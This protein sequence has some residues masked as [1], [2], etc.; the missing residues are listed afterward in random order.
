M[1][2]QADPEGFVL[3]RLEVEVK[4]PGL[5]VVRMTDRDSPDLCADLANAIVDT[6]VNRVIEAERAQKLEAEQTR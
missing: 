6:Y 3:K 4:Q 2:S 5:I 1:L